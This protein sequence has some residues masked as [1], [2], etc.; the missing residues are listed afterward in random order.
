MV[1]K[2]IFYL[3]DEDGDAFLF[4]RYLKKHKVFID[5]VST[6]E[7]A[8]DQFDPHKHLM[9]VCDWNLP[10]GDGINFAT[11]IRKKNSDFPIVFL[12]GAFKN[13]YLE[14]ASHFHPIACLEKDSEFS[15]MEKILDITKNDLLPKVR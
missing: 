4:E 5:R 12:S 10:D 13:E 14:K 7:E 1:D 15:Y 8:M 3:E 9:V 6:I 2:R 11:Y